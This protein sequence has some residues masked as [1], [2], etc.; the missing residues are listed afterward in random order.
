[1][2]V[3]ER[4]CF[5]GVT[6]AADRVSALHRPYLAKRRRSMHIVTITALDK[7]FVDSVVIRLSKI[8]FS[9]GVTAIAEIGLRSSEEM[10][11]LFGVVRRVAV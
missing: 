8:S 9:G 1:V 7:T 3:H 4:P 2:F 6:L 10:L 11:R 5:V